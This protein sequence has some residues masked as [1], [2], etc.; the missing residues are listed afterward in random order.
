[1]QHLPRSRKGE[2]VQLVQQCGRKRSELYFRRSDVRRH[3]NAS[4]YSKPMPYYQFS[5]PRRYLIGFHDCHRHPGSV[6]DFERRNSLLCL[7]LT[8]QSFHSCN[9][10]Y[11]ASDYYFSQMRYAHLLRERRLD[12]RSTP[13]L[14]SLHAPL[15]A[16]CIQLRR[17]YVM[18]FMY[19]R[20]PMWM[21]DF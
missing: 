3:R 7:P 8:L 6:F 2:Q 20:E 15:G 19:K 17:L 4:Y 14:R 16:L 21:V 5:R 1:M 9:C 12:R 13:R 18:H 10:C 11:Y